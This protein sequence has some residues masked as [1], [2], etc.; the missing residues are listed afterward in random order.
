M[1]RFERR[2]TRENRVF[3]SSALKGEVSRFLSGIVEQRERRNYGTLGGRSTCPEDECATGRG[4][5]RV[6][7]RKRMNVMSVWKV[8]EREERSGVGIV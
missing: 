1:Q 5:E 7:K 3:V 6:W 8:S 4:R 2:R